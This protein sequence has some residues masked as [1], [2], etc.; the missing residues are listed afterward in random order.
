MLPIKKVVLYKHG[1]GY[2][3]REGEVD[4]DAAVELQFK[5]GEM[6]DVLKSL[7]VLD[8][9]GGIVS[10]ISYESTE[11]VE[12]QLEDIAIRVPDG[13]A[14]TGLLSQVKGARVEAILKRPD[15]P[16]DIPVTFWD[17]RLTTMQASAVLRGRGKDARK[18]KMDVVSAQIMLQSYLDARS[19]G[20]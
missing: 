12:R 4:G 1:V 16:L 5:S 13:N 14:W 19:R 15:D 9:G 3:E 7:T 20:K 8:L 2:F 6:N 17:E 11:P 18:A 10:S